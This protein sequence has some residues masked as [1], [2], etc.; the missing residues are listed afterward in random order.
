MLAQLLTAEIFSF[1][2]IFCRIGS[3][4]MLM[5]GYGEAY[6][7]PR[8]RL[9]LALLFSLLLVPVIPG[10]PPAPAELGG[11]VALLVG[12]I[13]IG[14]MLGGLARMLIAGVHVAG[15]IIA[16]QSSLSSA[17][18]SNITGFQGQDTSL[19]NLLSMT[20][21]VLIFV[22]D[23][24]HLMLRSLADSYSLFTPGL[25]PLMEDVA[26]QA[27]RTIASTFRIAMQ[28]ASPHLVVGML[29]YLGAGIVARLM[30]NLQ[31][32]FIMM[33]V[34]LFISFCVLMACFSAI[35]LWYMEYLQGALGAFASP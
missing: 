28:L 2:L 33:P 34:Q 30:P 16:Y 13:A 29:L 11:L 4:I 7:A 24:H 25:F 22:T 3:A 21:V 27:S 6:V 32:F 19:G 1:L 5:P 31:I 12:E 20:T 10:L 9:M 35:M 26:T 8:V 23:L 18:T 14:L 17:L 15:G